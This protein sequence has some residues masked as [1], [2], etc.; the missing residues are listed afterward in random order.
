MAN[1]NNDLL[2]LL[3]TRKLLIIQEGNIYKF[4]TKEEEKNFCKSTNYS[5]QKHYTFK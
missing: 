5:L 1:Y 2:E 3:E 4:K